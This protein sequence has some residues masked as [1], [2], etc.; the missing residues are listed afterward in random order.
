VEVGLG[1]LVGLGVE[2]APLVVGVGDGVRVG[3]A[4]GR[5]VGDAKTGYLGFTLGIKEDVAGLR[6]QCTTPRPWA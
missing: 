5:D 2:V 6:S 1:V 4:L 3:V